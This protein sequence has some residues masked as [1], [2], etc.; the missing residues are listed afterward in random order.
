MVLAFILGTIFGISLHYA[1][2]IYY[3]NT[4]EKKDTVK[5]TTYI[6]Q[7]ESGQTGVWRDKEFLDH[8]IE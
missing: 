1:S 3:V 2:M 7:V 5:A 4:K 8:S 6:P